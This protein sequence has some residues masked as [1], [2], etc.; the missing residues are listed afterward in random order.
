[1]DTD[2]FTIGHSTHSIAAFLRLLSMHRIQAVADVRSA[3][4]SKF[5]PQFNRKEL[6]KSLADA[7]IRYVFLGKEL[8]A[9][10]DDPACY[11]ADKV[12]YDRLARTDLFQA[13]LDRIADGAK[14]HRIA[15][16]CAEKDPLQCHRT[17]LVAREL[18]R[19]GI[20]V[21][22]ILADGSLEKQKE[23]VERLLSELGLSTDDM[24]RSEN[25]VIDEAYAKQ[26]DRI[27]YDRSSHQDRADAQ[28]E[29]QAGA[30]KVR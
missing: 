7:G 29:E 6:Q 9:R 8:G 22:H 5:N 14:A 23:S 2:V 16:M 1:M 30:R 4:F 28:D 20:H 3:P 21:T 19:R 27:A 13:G 25:D 18:V 10:S 26:S 15:M 24:F 17:I 12:Q 11:V